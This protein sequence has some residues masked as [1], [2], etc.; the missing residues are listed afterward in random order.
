MG[1]STKELNALIFREKGDHEKVKTALE[2]RDL[3]LSDV[4]VHYERMLGYL[5]IDKIRER[6]RK[7]LASEH[8]QNFLSFTPQLRDI[9]PDVELRENFL[10]VHRNHPWEFYTRCPEGVEALFPNAYF[11]NLLQKGVDFFQDPV[12][13]K[14]FQFNN[15]ARLLS[16]IEGEELQAGIQAKLPTPNVKEVNMGQRKEGGFACGGMERNFAEAARK[17]SGLVK[18]NGDFLAKMYHR[19]GA[20]KAT[21]VTVMANENGMTP[22]GAVVWQDYLYATSQGQ[23]EPLV[24]AINSQQRELVLPNFI[25]RPVRPTIGLTSKRLFEAFGN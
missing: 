24:E 10:T 23:H 19:K 4:L 21:K 7:A 20:E 2:A 11:R 6:V 13:F 3:S 17:G 18:V 15:A 22:E 16:A 12:L 8:P 1:F 25:L 5:G 14:I 9:L